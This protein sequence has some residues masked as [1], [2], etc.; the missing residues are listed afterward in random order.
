[1][2]NWKCPNCKR[3]TKTEDKIIMIRCKCGDYFE[4]LCNE[5]RLNQNGNKRF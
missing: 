3:K 4:D 1:M 5:R 2:K